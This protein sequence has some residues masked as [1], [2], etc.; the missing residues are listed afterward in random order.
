MITK[1]DIGDAT[2][3]IFICIALFM[4][5][6]NWNWLNIFSG[7]PDELP[8][9][10]TPSLIT[11]KYIHQNV[12][13]SLIFLLGGGFAL[14]EGEF[15]LLTIYSLIGNSNYYLCLI[16]KKN[17]WKSV[18]YVKNAWN[19]FGGIERIALFVAAFLDLPFRSNIHRI[20]LKRCR[21]QCYVTSI[22]RNGIGDGS[23]S[24]VFNVSC[25]SFMFNGFSYPSGNTSKCKI[26]ITFY[27]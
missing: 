1:T 5:P 9:A 17:R 3:A 6:A 21:C 11:W 14:S 26:R 23:S 19:T 24:I 4:L 22:R 25:R 20:R 2:P 13:W 7:K 15:H 18:W 16:I 12:P 27:S 8:K 10:T